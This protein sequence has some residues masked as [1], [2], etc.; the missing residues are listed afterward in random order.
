MANRVLL[1]Q[2]YPS[3]SGS[4]ALWQRSRGLIPAGTQTLAKGP[5]QYVDGVAP[6]YLV[7]GQGAR[8]WD[9]DGNEFIDMTMAVGPLVLG[10]QYPAVDRAISEQLCSPIDSPRSRG[11]CT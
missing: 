9:V 1:D 2:D 8:V 6:K 11:A 4:Q 10:Y 5:T 7:R 3:I